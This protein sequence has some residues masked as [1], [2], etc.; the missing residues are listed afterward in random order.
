MQHAY[1]TEARAFSRA[2]AFLYLIMKAAYESSVDD[3]GYRV[4][5][6][7]LV[8]TMR[9]LSKDW[10][11]STA[12]VRRFLL[13]A[14]SGSQVVLQTTHERTKIRI[15]NY[16]RYHLVTEDSET[17]TNRKRSDKRTANVDI[18]KKEETKKE[19][20]PS[21]TLPAEIDTFEVRSALQRWLSFKAEKR[22]GYKSTGLNG[23][24]SKLSKLTP[25]RIVAA[26][27]HSIAANYS[28]IFE[29]IGNGASR[30]R[31]TFEKSS[32]AIADA[33]DT[34]TRKEHDATKEALSFLAP[35]FI[36][37]PEVKP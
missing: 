30:P 22:Q 10:G 25:E 3:F 28:G 4:A 29:P 36:N 19:E 12:K 21:L 6:G 37:A 16:D 31:T 18:Y 1:W 32:A 23:L 14:Q 35:L 5:R 9:Q 24:V 7:E 27:D 34:A 17:Q 33:I 8:T 26:V 2:E 11:W 15:T 20:V 13:A